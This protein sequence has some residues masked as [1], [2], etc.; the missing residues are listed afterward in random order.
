MAESAFHTTV[1]QILDGS[2]TPIDAVDEAVS[3]GEWTKAAAP[4]PTPPAMAITGG[5][6]ADRLAWVFVAGYQAAN[7]R[8][9]P[10]LPVDGWAAYLVSE[11]RNGE[12]PGVTAA[13]NDGGFLL[14]GHKTWLAA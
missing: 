13:P 6:I 8:V 10:E 4:L 7:R 3:L 14:N 11:D 5:A 9:F 1:A 12:L 2:I